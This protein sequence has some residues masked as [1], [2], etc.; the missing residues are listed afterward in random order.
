ML[1]IGNHAASDYIEDGYAQA[2]DV[3]AIEYIPPFI[4]LKN[5]LLQRQNQ[6]DE[7]DSLLAQAQDLA[8]KMRNTYVCCEIQ[9]QMANN[10]IRRGETESARSMLREARDLAQRISA[11]HLWVQAWRGLLPLIEDPGTEP[12][13]EDLLDFA[14]SVGDTELADTIRALSIRS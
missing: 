7:A 13:R 4:V 3:N 11:R 9:I 6:F 14:A 12:G 8:V 10:L 2:R 1:V 5:A